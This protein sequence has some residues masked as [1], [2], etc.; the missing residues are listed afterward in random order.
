MVSRRRGGPPAH[1]PSGRGPGCGFA[2]DRAIPPPSHAGVGFG[3]WLGSPVWFCCSLGQREI[4]L[5]RNQDLTAGGVPHRPR[6]TLPPLHFGV[7]V[8]GTSLAPIQTR[9]SF[10]VSFHA[11]GMGNGYF[12]PPCTRTSG[13]RRGERAKRACAGGGRQIWTGRREKIAHPSIAI[14]NGCRC[15]SNK[16]PVI[17]CQIP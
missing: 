16:R 15:M 4:K 12:S 5:R 10:S 17:S 13:R 2:S 14:I 1:R 8:K 9:A 7:F 6:S 3:L 11:G